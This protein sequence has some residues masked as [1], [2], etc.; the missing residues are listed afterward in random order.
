MHIVYV[1]ARM[2]RRISHD[3]IITTIRSANVFIKFISAVIE[4]II[5][6][7]VHN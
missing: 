5:V 3:E 6:S 7:A 4:R 1:S 2:N